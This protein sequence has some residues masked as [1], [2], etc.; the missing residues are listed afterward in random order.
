M[1]ALWKDSSECVAKI[2]RFSHQECFNINARKLRDK[3]NYL[4]IVHDQIATEL[5]FKNDNRAARAF[6]LVIH[7][8]WIVCVD[9]EIRRAIQF[10]QGFPEPDGKCNRTTVNVFQNIF[11]SMQKSVSR[12]FS[13]EIRLKLTIYAYINHNNF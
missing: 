1:V 8:N 12:L 10:G 5:W 6:P 4:L 13:I 11:N 2:H 9:K 7:H 3:L